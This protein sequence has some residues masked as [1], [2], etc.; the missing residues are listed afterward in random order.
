MRLKILKILTC[1][2]IISFFIGCATTEKSKAELSEN[3]IVDI[4]GTY[5][6]GIYTNKYYGFKLDIPKSYIIQDEK[7]KEHVVSEGADYFYGDEASREYIKELAA[8]KV[9]NIL[10][11]TKYEIGSP[12]LENPLLQ[13]IGENLIYNPGVKTGADYLWHVQ[14]LFK[15][16]GVKL[17]NETEIMIEEVN[18]IKF[19]TYSYEMYAKAVYFNQKWY[20]KK[21]GD[22]M[23]CIAL[24]YNSEQ[25][26]NELNDI[27]NTL[28]LL[29]QTR[30]DKN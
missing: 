30:I 27:F 16:S 21:V 11:C 2:L 22:H 10:M 8:E 15:E 5:N 24:T 12:V 6:D 7:M 23:L 20:T 1:I 19:H 9:Y 26:Y 25:G 4:Y 29:K 28:E 3:D 14:K 13:I 18:G 17:N